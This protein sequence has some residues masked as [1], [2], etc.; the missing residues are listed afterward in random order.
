M[1]NNPSKATTK[2]Q[3]DT[4]DDIN[5]A[6]NRALGI[7]HSVALQFDGGSSR[8]NDDLIAYAL[9]AAISEVRNIQSYLL[10]AINTES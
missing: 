9:D 6:S 10:N 7:I 8:L 2:I 4:I 1:K 3:L 5:M